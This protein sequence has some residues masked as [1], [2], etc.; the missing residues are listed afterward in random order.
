MFVQL[1][2]HENRLRL[3]YVLIVRTYQGDAGL[4]GI[5]T[6]QMCS[7]IYEEV[8]MSSGGATRATSRVLC[9]LPE[10]SINLTLATVS[11]DRSIEL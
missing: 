3:L 5:S 11:L 9:N 2:V 10:T 8:Y 4:C 1:I 6:A 7:Y